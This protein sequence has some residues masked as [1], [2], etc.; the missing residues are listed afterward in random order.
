[1]ATLKDIAEKAQVSVSTVSR[2][3]NYDATLSVSTQT[4]QTILHIADELNYKKS[5]KPKLAEQQLSYQP[6]RKIL[7]VTWYNPMQELADPYYLSVRLGIEAECKLQQFEI[8]ATI[9]INEQ[10]LTHI[11]FG[12]IDGVIALGKF[13]PEQVAFLATLSPN[14]IFAD[15]NPN[16]QRFTCVVADLVGATTQVLEYLIGL[17]HQKIGFI[18][19][20]DQVGNEHES[21]LIDDVRE[22]TF[23]NFMQ[24]RAQFTPENV[25]LGRFHVSDGYQLMQTAIANG[26]LPTAFFI[27][28]D[29]MA[30]GA[31]KA[32]HEHGIRVPEQVSI[33]GFNN[34]ATAEFSQPALSTVHLHTHELGQ[35][36]VK[37]LAQRFLNGSGILPVQ[38]ILPTELIIRD[39]CRRLQP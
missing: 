2:V 14:L 6:T 35:Y 5:K 13:T 39:S 26:N 38:V 32:L 18:G 11:E 16:P 9:Q 21:V 33:F 31:L 24:L 23:T 17:G 27:A 4:R 20:Q 10:P 15:S 36:S 19:G 34:L 29:S 8:V 12:G 7:L 22:Q 37:M 25:Y 1:M 3:L 30:I 28:S